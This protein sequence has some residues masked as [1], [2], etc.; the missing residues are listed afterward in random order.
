MLLKLGDLTAN[1]K[2]TH[3]IWSEIPETGA[4][5][6]QNLQ[7]GR[8]KTQTSKETSFLGVGGAFWYFHCFVEG[9]RWQNVKTWKFVSAKMS[10][11]M[12]SHVEHV[13]PHVEPNVEPVEPNLT[14]PSFFQI[15][16]KLGGLKSFRRISG[17]SVYFRRS[18][19]NLCAFRRNF[20]IFGQILLLFEFV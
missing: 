15:L 18:S 3:A 2:T 13:E 10:S 4:S 17:F 20:G 5:V 16:G 8:S 9:F 7:Q 19:T 11:T 12:S 6:K 1:H 14:Q